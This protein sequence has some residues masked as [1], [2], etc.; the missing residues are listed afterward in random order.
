MPPCGGAP[1]SKASSICPNRSCATSS[2]MPINLNIR[3]WTSRSWIL[4]DPPA[5]SLPFSTMS[6]WAPRTFAGSFSIRWL[7]SDNGAVKGWWLG[8]QRC[9]SSFQKAN[10]KSVTQEKAR[11]FGSRNPNSSPRW[12]RNRPSA[13]ATTSASSATKS[14]ISP[15][16]NSIS[17]LT[18]PRTSSERCLAKEDFTLPSLSSA[19]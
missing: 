3:L 15:R 4:I 5:I 6:Y 1:Y 18:L 2:P 8:S 19:K 16:S 9:S 12:A 11:T 17:F 7:S 10:G 13:L 14:S